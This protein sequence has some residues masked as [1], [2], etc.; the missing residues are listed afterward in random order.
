MSRIA[1]SKINVKIISVLFAVVLWLYVASE[2]NPTEYKNIKDVP[3]RLTNMEA[4]AKSG[5]SVR[6]LQEYKV[7]V[8]LQGKRS[9]L[10]EIKVSDILVEA[11]L[12]GFTQKGVNNVPVE[13]KGIPTNVDLVDVVP[14]HIKVNLETVHSVQVPVNAMVEGTPAIGYTAL[15]PLVVPAEILVK[16]PESLL[17]NIR[18]YTATVKLNG[19]TNDIKE[20]VPVMVIDSDNNEIT[21]IELNPN[22]VEVT[23]P[24]RRTKVVPI[25][26][27]T[28]GSPPP[29]REIV[30]I[31]P[32]NNSI[33][34]YGE[35]ALVEQIDSIKTEPI[36]VSAMQSNQTYPAKLVL[37]EGVFVLDGVNKV[38]VGFRIERII[39]STITKQAISFRNIAD[40]LK[41]EN[42]AR[43]PAL[44]I[45]LKGRED[46]LTP[47]T[48]QDIEVY[49][50][51]ANLA[52]GIHSVTLQVELPG[53]VELLS[54]KPSKVDI[55]LVSSN[56]GE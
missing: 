35:Q 11:D 34:I 56:T 32:V 20:V 12:R 24:V 50:N 30:S 27:I 9:V 10:S 29:D 44:E 37:P 51:L 23:V 41:V 4:V 52:E 48:G 19:A 8:T 28:T 47:I 18:V 13:I 5:F 2:Q 49:A 43:L 17:N 22:I 46:I 45:E 7:D 3:V 39:T 54:V 38:D 53:G 55:S 36:D 16:G 14:R 15:K 33:A 6:D 40:G 31:R 26:V 42:A 21:G 1:D 25:E